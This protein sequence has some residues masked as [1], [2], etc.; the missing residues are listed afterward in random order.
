[1]AFVLHSVHDNVAFLFLQGNHEGTEVATEGYHPA[2]D[3]RQGSFVL[4]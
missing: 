1:M 4:C 3:A 2:E